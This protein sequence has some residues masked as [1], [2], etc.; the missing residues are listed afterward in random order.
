MAAGDIH[1]SVDLADVTQSLKEL[2]AKADAIM[3]AQD[4]INAAVTAIQAFFADL[5]TAL[6]AIQAELANLA[7]AVDT[8]ALNA[9][10][11]Q[12]PAVQASVDALETPPA[13]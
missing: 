8:S 12:L 6:A 13:A 3:A 7:P 2:H 5:A 9:L 4:D 10:V 1:L 11:A